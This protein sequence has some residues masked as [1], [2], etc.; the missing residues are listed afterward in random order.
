LAI[1]ASL[2]AGLPGGLVVGYFQQLV[3][4]LHLFLELIQVLVQL[5]P[6]SAV[7][8]SKWV[9]IYLSTN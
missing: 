7:T 1:F 8:T 4:S 5:L 6:A 3:K 9:H 2:E